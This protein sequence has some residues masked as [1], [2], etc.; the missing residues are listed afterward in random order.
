MY[1]AIRS[2]Y[3]IR[4]SYGKRYRYK[5]TIYAVYP[6]TVRDTENSGGRSEVDGRCSEVA[7]RG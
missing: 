5:P 6:Y 4:C 2:S 1:T 7:V 3:V